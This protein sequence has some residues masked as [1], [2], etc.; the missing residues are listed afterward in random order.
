MVVLYR[1][2]DLFQHLTRFL[3]KIATTEDYQLHLIS[4]DFVPL[5]MTKVFK[6]EI[7]NED[8]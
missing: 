2:V 3:K 4:N 7:D 1:F 5:S 8:D 6:N